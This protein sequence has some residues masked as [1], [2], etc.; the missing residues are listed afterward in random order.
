MSSIALNLYLLLIF[1]ATCTFL[2]GWLIPLIIGIRRKRRQAGGTGLIA[3]GSIWGAISVILLSFTILSISRITRQLQSETFDAASY[4]GQTGTITLPWNDTFTLQFIGASSNGGNL[5]I[6]GKAGSAAAPTG[7]FTIGMVYLSSVIS[8][9]PLFTAT[10][11][12]NNPTSRMVSVKANEQT[13][14]S[15]GPPFTASVKVKQ[16]GTTNV[17]FDYKLEDSAG[18]SWRV[19]SMKETKNVG[20]T[21][22]DKTGKVVWKGHFQY[23]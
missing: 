2:F 21:V 9:T 20:F 16:D 4:K 19:S 23:G 5:N 12:P 18:N 15:F 3:A 8:N 10:T 17:V 14:L 11:W 13:A 7:T 6:I 1:L 22:S